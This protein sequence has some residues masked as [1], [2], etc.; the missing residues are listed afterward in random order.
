MDGGG[1]KRLPAR[2]Q[3][4]IFLIGALGLG[5][6]YAYARYIV[7]P[8]GREATELG[9]K[10]RSARERLQALEAAT[11]NEAT[12]REQYSQ[13]EQTVKSLRTLLPAE[14]EL[15]AVI[16][17]LSDLANQAQVK[18]QTIFPQ[19]SVETPEALAAAIKPG[20][21][22]ARPPVVY[23]E[24]PIQIDALAGYHQLGEFL[25]LVEGGKNPMRVSSLRISAN[26]KESKRHHIKL[27]LVAYFA[28]QDSGAL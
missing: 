23:R 8:L 27:V 14:E 9:Q 4:T 22:A 6:L 10:I 19:R 3:R 12:L 11:A 15:A 16:G 26:P 20:S 24:I 5:I 21:S 28:T 25:G 7:G 17:L 13:V 1:M 2:D 18:I